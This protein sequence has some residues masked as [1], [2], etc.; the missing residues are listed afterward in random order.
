MSDTNSQNPMSAAMDELRKMFTNLKL[1]NGGAIIEQVIRH[2]VT[3][4]V[5]PLVLSAVHGI[6]S[7]AGMAA[8]AAAIAPPTDPKAE[9]RAKAM[10]ELAA[11]QARLAELA[12]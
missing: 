11:V 4:I 2:T 1:P 6:F 5:E 8:Q 9:A 10:A 3:D 7:R 12:G